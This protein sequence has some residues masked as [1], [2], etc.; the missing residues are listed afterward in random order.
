MIQEMDTQEDSNQRH[1]LSQESIEELQRCEKIIQ[2]GLKSFMEVGHCLTVIRN[3]RLYR[4][5]FSSFESYCRNRWGISRPYAYKLIAGANVVADLSAEEDITVLPDN[6]NQVRKLTKLNREDRITVWKKVLQESAT[7]GKPIT[8][9]LVHEVV[10]I[11]CPEFSSP[12]DLRKNGGNSNERGYC[13]GVVK[14]IHDLERA[15]DSGN[16]SKL[17]ALTS[18]LRRKL[19]LE[20]RCADTS[21]SNLCLDA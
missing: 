17:A 15:I 8:A 5:E 18:L 4:G 7:T 9:R 6:A 12:S 20:P 21:D 3:N 19:H 16:L 2:N 13:E 1:F 11:I 14:V 10:E